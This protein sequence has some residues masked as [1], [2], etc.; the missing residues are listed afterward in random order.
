MSED[1]L[2]KALEAMR[3]ESI[4]PQQLADAGTRVREKLEKPGALCSE[5]QSQ[6]REYL[7]GGF[8]ANRRMLIED[9]LGRCPL[10]RARLADLRG[11]HRVIP[12]QVRHAA[13]PRWTA[14][15]A[16]AAVFLAALYL[17]RESIDTLL[18]PHGPRATVASVSGEL[19]LVPGGVLKPGATVG[20]NAVIRT[21]PGS[22][23]V[24]RL[25]DGSLV[26]VN[27]RTEMSIHA[28]W[29]GQSIQLPRGDIIVRAAKQ[30]RGH[31]RVQTRD[32]VASVKGTIFAVSTGLNGTIVSVVEGSVAV[33]QSGIETLLKPGEQAAS[34]PALVNSVES[35]I[36]WSPDA[37][38]Y[39]G[40][41]DSLA[42]I[43]KEIA[44]LPSPS[45]RT[46]SRLLEYMPANTIVYG[47]V[48]NL[49]GTIDQAIIMAE[50][51]AEENPA[52]NQ[53]W[54]SGIGEGLRQLIGRV[55]TVTP[56]LG[57]EIVYGICADTSATT[58][59]FP[60][61]LAEVREGKRPELAAALDHLATQMSQAPSYY[62]T[63]TLI[64]ASNS[65][66]N[67]QWL[68]EHLG[69]G[70]GSA[71]AQEIAARYQDGAAWLLGIDMDMIFPLAGTAQSG[72]INAQ[73][74][75][76][77]FL[78]QRSELGGQENE[79]TVSFRGPRT[80]LASVLASTGS[81]GA[82]EYLSGDSIAA[83]YV[84]TREP[85][86]LFEEMAAQ[87]SRLD[88]AFQSN[89]A[90]AEAKLGISFSNDLARAFG[91]ESAL[92]IEGISTA[93]PV[94][95]MAVQVNDAS[96]LETTI[97]R[98][99]DFANAELE[100]AGK[101]GRITLEQQVV[102]GRTWTTMMFPQQPVT[103]TWTYDRGY[104]VAA[105]DRGTAARAIA[106]RSG[107]SPLVWSPAFQQQLSP[108]AGLHPSGFAW[109]N[110]K[111]AFEGLAA[112]VP[113]PAIQKLVAERDPILVVFS[114]TME[115]IRAV[116]RTQLSGLVMNLILLQG[117]SGTRTGS[118]QLAPQSGTL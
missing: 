18:A 50:R 38:T 24:L 82:A 6:F 118:Q 75:K 102:D 58:K 70:S 52:F 5:F 21:G 106:T 73:Q 110:T 81:G 103:I 68:I 49:S 54:N 11:E 48:P 36:S 111:G 46:Q 13:W 10:C 40:V 116:S 57:D 19:Y 12:M 83:V 62:L 109:L 9:H 79:M 29:S 33:T 32:S 67:L 14:W 8:S 37:E 61:I 90:E 101:T 17:G 69:Q 4:D 45:L 47:A 88:P 74:V 94:W 41:L 34:N 2:E 44:A 93:G 98:L 31:L 112:L 23:A 3:S 117:L 16:A 77:I 64:V 25:A 72:F 26:D 107:G 53:W 91:T 80:G 28:A 108:S 100:K 96:T 66:V 30:H 7:D 63:D 86:Q 76:R 20:E 114:G 71:F 65:S 55:Q 89:L 99:V 105:S 92:A 22:R 84:S 85:Q 15:A 43:Q 42:H 27:E 87:F 95:M 104:M 97:R 35:A 56:L 59:A 39:L 115:Q 1:R 113:N 51:Q 60:V 78:E